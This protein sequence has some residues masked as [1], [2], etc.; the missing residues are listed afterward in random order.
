MDKPGEVMGLSAML[1]ARTEFTLMASQGLP[2]PGKRAAR[3]DLARAQVTRA[4]ADQGSLRDELEAELFQL[5]LEHLGTQAQLALLGTLDQHWAVAEDLA[6]TCCELGKGSTSDLY[7]AIQERA[8]LRQRRLGLEAREGDL[9]DGLER[10]VGAS[11][12]LDLKADLWGLPRPANPGAEA[13]VKDLLERNAEGRALDAE[14]G[15]ARAAIRS[16][17]L[18]RRPDL[19]LTTGLMQE[20][21]M[22]PGWRA[23]VGFAIPLFRARKQD[24]ALA[25]ARME[26]QGTQAGLEGLRRMVQARGRERARAWELAERTVRIVQDE[27]LPM[28]RANVDTLMARYEQGKA[29]FSTILVALNALQSDQETLLKAVTQVHRLSL[30]QY[31]ASLEAPAPLDAGMGTGTMPT[32]T[33]APTPTRRSSG[34]TAPAAAPTASTPTM[35][36]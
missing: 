4:E 27:L 33:A 36:M 18:D 8:R 30:Q 22:A 35:K 3:A 32:S 31:T 21:G 16:A 24:Q 25:R 6:R 15:V 28:G 11:A 19:R 20:K 1:P 29:E 17:E 10:L 34:G 14:V 2:W 7:Q 9:R 26:H 5:L 23:E 12:T 13:L